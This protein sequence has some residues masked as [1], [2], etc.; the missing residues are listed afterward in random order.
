VGKWRRIFVLFVDDI[1]K[2]V[3][4]S[5]S[6]AVRESGRYKGKTRIET[7]EREDY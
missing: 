7:F 3:F 2:D 1:F 4:A 5:Y 6:E